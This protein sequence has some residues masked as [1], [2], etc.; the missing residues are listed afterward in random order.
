M[1]L[2]RL[3]S[4]A[5]C[6]IAS[7][8]ALLS[9]RGAREAAAETRRVAVVVGHNTGG[10]SERPLRYAEDDAGKL[11]DVLV[12]LGDVDRSRL[13]VVRGRPR[14]AVIE[15]L[16]R[17]A[18]TV[19]AARQLPDDRVILTFFYSGH[20]DATSL[21]LGD[22]KL[23][24]AELKRLLDATGAEVR[25]T[26]VDGC[27]SGG[28]VATKGGR[29][30]PAFEIG[31][32]DQLTSAGEAT[33]TSSAADEASLES[34]EIRGSFFTHHL[35]SGLR[36]AADASG[37]GRVT[38][39]EAYE[40]A[41]NRTVVASAATGSA[42]QHPNY[43]YQLTGGGELVLTRVGERSASLRLPPGFSRALIT[44]VVR[45]QVVAELTRDQVRSLAVAPG[46]YAVRLWKGGEVLLGRVKASANS[47]T[48]VR[49]EQLTSMAKLQDNP[50][51]GGEA[52]PS[53]FDGGERF[54]QPMDEPL[55]PDAQQIY[56]A[57]VL[58]VGDQLL[59]TAN[60]TAAEVTNSNTLYVG[61]Y[62]RQIQAEQFLRLAGRPDLA[63]DVATRRST[64]VAFYVVG[65]IVAAGGLLYSLFGERC[66]PAPG[67]PD[68]EPC[69]DREMEAA[70][71]GLVGA[72]AGLGIFLAGMALGDGVPA[73]H[74]LREL[75]DRHNSNLR[76]RL[77]G[78]RP[79]AEAKPITARLQLR[80]APAV[81]PS[82]G[83]LTLM[84]RF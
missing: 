10:A 11:A 22:S 73:P 55:S 50:S 15:A 74:V 7:V 20:S 64:K 2:R 25:L 33:L 59:V 3:P 12:E 78:G 19:K 67:D 41:F 63:K 61:R 47:A 65:S 9:P 14:E 34:S 56:D 60:G 57:E 66:S 8:L 27:K 35:V 16:A 46:E 58:S 18:A 45:D 69:L 43:D 44:N 29:P 28:L 26:I 42:P 39:S 1:S 48:E 49:W 71:L 23:P 80:L 40:Y 54:A 4:I 84:G 82:G 17:A 70:T 77:R 37:D 38:L 24:Y 5:S 30:A 31:L 62:R 32:S 52:A 51:K 68:F 6:T 72:G 13:F 21:Q 83:G 75:A 36:G 81:T 79:A 53:V 76:V